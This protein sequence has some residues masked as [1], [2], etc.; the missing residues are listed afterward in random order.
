LSNAL[1]ASKHSYR[2]EG[3]RHVDGIREGSQE[4]S[5][6]NLSIALALPASNAKTSTTSAN[7]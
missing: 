2:D 6:R 5:G 3:V 4:T 1:A 7:R